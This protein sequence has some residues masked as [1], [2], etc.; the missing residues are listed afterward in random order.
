MVDIT[1]RFSVYNVGTKL[2]R[3]LYAVIEKKL[4]EK[5]TPLRAAAIADLLRLVEICA[6]LGNGPAHDRHRLGNV[7]AR[8]YYRMG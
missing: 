6:M 4:N 8:N 1:G 2:F 7:Q 5:R 3:D